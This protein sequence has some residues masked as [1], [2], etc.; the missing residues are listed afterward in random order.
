[1]VILVVDQVHGTPTDPHPPLDRGPVHTFTI[2]P[3][4]TKGGN[5]G[6]VN[7]EYP[8]PKIL[9]HLDQRKKPGQRNQVNP[10]ITTHTKRRVAPVAGRR[11]IPPHQNRR[12]QPRLRRSLDPAHLLA[13]GHHHRHLGPQLTPANRTK[14]VDQRPAAAGQKHSQPHRAIQWSKQPLHVYVSSNKPSTS[15]SLTPATPSTPSA[16][17]Q[18]NDS[19]TLARRPARR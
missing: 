11:V 1:M 3:L 12:L 16:A 13:V 19:G 15:V 5:Q 8:R 18:S 9:G 10:R 4:P 2:E 17:S 14:Q 7:I 6:R